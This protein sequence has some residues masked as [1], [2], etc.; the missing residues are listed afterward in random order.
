MYYVSCCVATVFIVWC[1]AWCIVWWLLPTPRAPIYYPIK[2]AWWLYRGYP[3][4]V[5]FETL[6]H[7]DYWAYIGVYKVR[8]C[9]NPKTI[10]EVFRT[11]DRFAPIEDIFKHHNMNGL[12]SAMNGDWRRFKAIRHHYSPQ[13][14]AKYQPLIK[15]ILLTH[16]IEPMRKDWVCIH[17]QTEIAIFMILEV[18]MFKNHSLTNS[19]NALDDTFNDTFNDTYTRTHIVSTLN[20]ITNQITRDMLLP[21]IF[22][23][24]PM[25]VSSLN[26]ILADKIANANIDSW[27]YKMNQES[28]K[29]C[30][31]NVKMMFFAGMDTL[32]SL[33]Q[34]I[35]AQAATRG[36]SSDVLKDKL[37]TPLLFMSCMTGVIKHNLLLLRKA[38]DPDLYFG[39]GKRVC[40]GRFLARAVLNELEELKDDIEIDEI[41]QEHH[42]FTMKFTPFR[43]R[44]V[45]KIVAFSGN[46]EQTTH[47]MN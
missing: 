6:S 24:K 20:E 29:E 33:T 22:W 18:F 45:K 5:F 30:L 16:L 2:F 15:K 34:A 13:I 8:V 19:L 36:H 38:G 27:V 32:A 10:R 17:E 40:V 46:S 41:P 23:S 26:S 21:K 11:C 44:I 14:V 43:A 25:D 7:N 47:A 1:I 12:F 3:M 42:V 31:A 37:V 35:I 4:H 28:P 9:S 39:R